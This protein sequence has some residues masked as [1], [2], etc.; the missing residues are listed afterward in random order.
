MLRLSFAFFLAIG[1]SASLTAQTTAYARLDYDTATGAGATLDKSGTGRF[2]MNVAGPTVDPFELVGTSAAPTV[3]VTDWLSVYDAIAAS[4]AGMS[5]PESISD[6]ATAEIDA[7]RIPLSLL[8]WRYDHLDTLAFDDD[9]LDTDV[10]GFFR[11]TDGSGALLN[12][13]TPYRTRTLFA[14]APWAQTVAP[15]VTFSLPSS[16]VAVAPE[17]TLVASSVRLNAGDGSGWRP[18]APGGSLNVSYSSPGDKTVR[19]KA[20]VTL[21]GS[22]VDVQSRSVITVDDALGA[23][24]KG[25]FGVPMPPLPVDDGPPY[26]CSDSPPRIA[27]E[28]TGYDGEADYTSDWLF[29]AEPYCADASGLSDSGLAQ[30]YGGCRP[31]GYRYAV[32][33]ADTNQTS[34]IQNPV[35]F[36]N[37]YDPLNELDLRKMERE[38]GRTARVSS[39]AP[40]KLLIT[41]LR[42][43]GYDV[44]LFNHYDSKDYI[45]RNAHALVKLLDDI[46]AGLPQGEN[47]QGVAG[48]SMG[49]LVSRYALLYM[50]D[51]HRQGTGPP[52]N[53]HA[54]FSFDA[55]QQGGNIPIGLQHHVRDIPGYVSTLAERFNK[56]IKRPYNLAMFPFANAREDYTCYIKTPDAYARDLDRPGTRQLL[57]VG[58]V[59][60]IDDPLR[61]E[62]YDEIE[63]LGDYPKQSRNLG[64]AN[65]SGTGTRQRRTDDSSPF[66]GSNQLMVEQTFR[67][68]VGGVGTARVLRTYTGPSNSPL[69]RRVEER[70]DRAC[71]PW[72]VKCSVVLNTFERNAPVGLLPYDYT[73]GGYRPS[74]KDVEPDFSLPEPVFDVLT[75]IGLP[76]INAETDVHIERHAF[77]NTASALDYDTQG[78]GREELFTTLFQNQNLILPLSSDPAV[79]AERT[80]FDAI[81]V[82]G[83]YPG[84]S[85]GPSAPNEDHTQPPAVVGDFF[86]DELTKLVPHRAPTE[87]AGATLMSGSYANARFSGSTTLIEEST[88]TV[89]A[90]GRVF[91]ADT[92][93]AEL[94]SF[95]RV[96]GTLFVEEGAILDGVRL[97]VKDGGRVEILAGAELRPGQ[98]GTT[99][100]N[101]GGTL[102]TYGSASAPVQILGTGTTYG[103]ALT[104][105]GGGTAKLRHTVAQGLIG[106]RVYGGTLKGDHLAVRGA[107]QSGI[108][109]ING[110]EV[111]LQDTEVSG[112]LGVGSSLGHGINVSDGEFVGAWN[113]V[114]VTGGEYDLQRPATTAPSALRVSSNAGYGI[115]V[116]NQSWANMGCSNCTT[117]FQSCGGGGGGTIPDGAK[118][119]A[120]GPTLP[121]ATLYGGRN[122]VYGN[123][124]GAFQAVN[125]LAAIAQNTWWGHYPSNSTDFD[126]SA[127]LCHKI[128]HSPDLSSAPQQV[129]SGHLTGSGTASHASS[130]SGQVLEARPS[131]LASIA[132]AAVR[133][134]G[135]VRSGTG[136]ISKAEGLMR[137]IGTASADSLLAVLARRYALAARALRREQGHE[138]TARGVA[139]VADAPAHPLNRLAASLRVQSLVA[140]GDAEAAIRE[141]RRLLDRSPQ[142]TAWWDDMRRETAW[143]LLGAYLADGDEASAAD[144]AHARQTVRL[145][146][147]LG[148]SVALAGE[149][150][151][152]VGETETADADAGPLAKNAPE[153]EETGLS[154]R[155]NPARGAVE[156]RLSLAEAADVRVSVLDMLGREVAV[157][158]DGEQAA[159]VLRLPF[160]PEAQR[161]APGVY[162]VRTDV[163]DAV[164]VVRFTIVR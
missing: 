3:S 120:K 46:N 148:D 126:D 33:Y 29:D 103:P 87:F 101:T 93:T 24:A 73:A 163:G 105:W 144:M 21:A 91:I 57:T 160:D 12:P 115:R 154:V 64:V 106:V 52:P 133:A 18:L 71:A 20:K 42:E 62:L 143:A 74:T 60:G 75:F 98:S 22:L 161:L 55:P 88:L 50:E 131:S 116:D 81:F 25:A 44:V 94:L 112:A 43:R 118:T 119:S 114:T 8:Y 41:A 130:K 100:V 48:L 86:V 78:V 37:G 155:P 129:G 141:G 79:R 7:G 65:G 104:I 139:A 2:L 70:K 136:S 80:P 58:T 9:R 66:F 107:A 89:S 63:A 56:H 54:W 92:F 125:E 99:T 158:I 109:V 134:A 146:K 97:D 84:T 34:T 6:I 32:Y 53:V 102:E 82:P 110:G 72:P 151:A 36:V 30:K 31:A 4:V 132:D 13:A 5:S 69:T 122:S 140:S 17:A 10:N 149:L 39:P 26:S 152:L 95:I 121:S 68:T 135:S 150:D 47:I 14:T 49:G 83:F 23:I 164:E 1:S 96:Y 128:R 38:I 123:G 85:T 147:Q 90:G 16:L 138:S 162:I 159:G 67:K 124:L 156:V 153:S 59:Y 117:T 137:G 142:G 11:P 113:T 28:S 27:S 35:V 45:Q 51:R 61:R 77:V 111:Y 108:T 127:A 76:L 19:L 157:L 15:Y 40:S 145:L